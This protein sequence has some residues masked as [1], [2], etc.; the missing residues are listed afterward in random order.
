VPEE[1]SRNRWKPPQTVPGLTRF[2]CGED[3][4]CPG[5]GGGVIGDLTGFVALLICGS[6][7]DTSTDNLA[8]AGDTVLG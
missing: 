1:K 7:P 8:G 3:N 4:A 6:P 2:L 5:L